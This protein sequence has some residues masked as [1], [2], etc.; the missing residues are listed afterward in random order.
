MHD[1]TTVTAD[2]FGLQ[3]NIACIFVHLFLQTILF[4]INLITATNTHGIVRKVL[5]PSVCIQSFESLCSKLKN[6][7]T[8]DHDLVLAPVKSSMQWCL[9]VRCIILLKPQ[10]AN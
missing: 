9:V 2:F 5:G 4:L 7:H 1:C 10:Y 6:E 8:S 3:C